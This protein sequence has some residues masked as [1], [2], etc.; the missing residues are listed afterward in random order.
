MSI[1][2][3]LQDLTVKA[4]ADGWVAG[5][6]TVPAGAR[7]VHDYWDFSN[8]ID[9]N[10]VITYDFAN[11]I[12]VYPQNDYNQA[13]RREVMNAAESLKN[14]YDK[15]VNVDNVVTKKTGFEISNS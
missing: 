2:L 14:M 1:L 3:G 11:D 12:L 8:A 5:T 7:D 10:D 9:P 6:K 4:V 13:Q 15:F